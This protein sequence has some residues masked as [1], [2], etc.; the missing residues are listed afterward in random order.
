[1]AD[2]EQKKQA[3][4]D[5]LNHEEVPLLLQ[6][7]QLNNAALCNNFRDQIVSTDDPRVN[8]R[9]EDICQKLCVYQNLDE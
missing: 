1:V 2:A 8:S 5:G 3:L 4:A 7:Q 9:W 6:V